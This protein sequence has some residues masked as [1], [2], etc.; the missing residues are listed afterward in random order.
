[1]FARLAQRGFPVLS[2]QLHTVWTDNG[3]RNWLLSQISHAT[4]LDMEPIARFQGLIDAVERQ[5][6]LD[7]A[8]NQMV[9]SRA[10]CVETDLSESVCD[11]IGTYVQ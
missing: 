1:M 2:D 4:E 8:L 10:V 6:F 3:A 11:I 7:I 9:F 5:F